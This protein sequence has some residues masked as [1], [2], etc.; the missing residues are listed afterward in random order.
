MENM[1]SDLV[2]EKGSKSLTDKIEG[3]VARSL[4]TDKGDAKDTDFIKE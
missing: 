3:A 2:K 1:L 4:D